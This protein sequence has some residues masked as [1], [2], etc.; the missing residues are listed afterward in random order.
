MTLYTHSK[1]APKRTSLLLAGLGLLALGQAAP[2][3]AQ[4]VMTGPT[5]YHGDPVASRPNP[6]VTKLL[7]A[8]QLL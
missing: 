4:V 7:P 8:S 5:L 6:A 1:H 2:V 3:S